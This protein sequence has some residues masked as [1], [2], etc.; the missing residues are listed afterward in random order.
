MRSSEFLLNAAIVENMAKKA[1]QE[2]SAL[3]SI[4]DITRW[5]WLRDDT[6]STPAVVPEILEF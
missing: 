5:T 1:S 6:I 3:Q 2:N 4:K